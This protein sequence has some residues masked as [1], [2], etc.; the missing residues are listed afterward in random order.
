MVLEPSRLDVPAKGVDQKIACGGSL[1]PFE[2]FTVH[3]VAGGIVFDSPL[4]PGSVPSTGVS[5]GHL[6]FPRFWARTLAKPGGAQ[7]LSENGP[8]HPWEAH[9]FP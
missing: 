2:W 4:K 9:N 6:I 3:P 8:L 1:A 5:M 7:A